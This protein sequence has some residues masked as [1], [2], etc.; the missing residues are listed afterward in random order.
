MYKSTFWRLTCWSPAPQ[1]EAGCYW[2]PSSP[3]P[4]CVQSTRLSRKQFPAKRCPKLPQLFLYGTTGWWRDLRTLKKCH[5]TTGNKSKW[6]RGKAA[7]RQARVDCPLVYNPKSET[8]GSPRLWQL[9]GWTSRKPWLWWWAYMGLGCS[10]LTF[11]FEYLAAELTCFCKTVWL[12]QVSFIHSTKHCQIF[13]RGCS[14]REDWLFMDKELCIK[15]V[16]VML[17]SRNHS[18]QALSWRS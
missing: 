12:Q 4:S 5:Y 10:V 7:D 9:W 11:W 13:L 14:D 16:A 18:L 17:F 1:V 8:Q 6:G 3:F 15:K 2:F